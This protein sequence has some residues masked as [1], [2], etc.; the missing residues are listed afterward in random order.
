MNKILTIIIPTYNMEK[1]LRR[2]LDSLIIDEEGMKQL[3]VLVI[4]DGSKDSSSQIAHEYQD[5]YPD[6]F[7]VIDKEN[8]N[9][10]SCFN[11]AID[12]SNGLYTRLLDADDWFIN[13][14]LS[15]FINN[16]QRMRNEVDIIFTNYTIIKNNGKYKKYELSNLEYNTTYEIS[17]IDFSETG[18]S[19]LFRM[20]AMTFN[21]SLLKKIGLKLQ[22]GIS[23]TDA[24]YCFYPFINAQ[25]CI[26][27]DINLYQYFIGREGQTVS[28]ES[29]VKSISSF[30]MVAKPM[31]NA[32]LSINSISLSKRKSLAEFLTNSL[33]NIYAI[34][35]VL[36]KQVSEEA[37]EYLIDI[38][39][40]VRK[41]C[42]LNHMIKK[43]TYKR[44][45]FIFIW[46]IFH[47]RMTFL[48]LL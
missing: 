17:N 32:Y 12:I 3:E 23:Y 8:G 44:V 43:Q 48:S 2:C 37:W 19:L 9:Y 29:V 4:N 22:T 13:D 31:L 6:T 21:T 1:Y 18:N 38:D 47:I 33:Y 15:M 5:K 34:V 36:S 39:S 25:N 42:I 14:S 41:E 30:Y 20:H 28:K 35:L 45:Y 26:F 11:K 27:F 7:R 24:E 10:G 40:R 16:I 46:R